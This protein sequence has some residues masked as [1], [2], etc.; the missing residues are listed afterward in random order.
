MKKKSSGLYR[1]R[2]NAR[3]YEQ[4]DRQHFDSASIAAPVT[5]NVT[6]CVC[7]MLMLMALWYS[8]L[9]DVQGA[10]LLGQFTNGEEFIWKYQKE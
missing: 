2:L 3:G 5:N 9:L 10:F 7:F 6:I 8:Y 1:A 4:V